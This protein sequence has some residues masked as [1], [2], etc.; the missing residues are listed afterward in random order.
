EREVQECTARVLGKIR[1]LRQRVGAGEVDQLALEVGLALAGAATRV[2]DRHA[3]VLLGERLD[4]GLVVRLL[5]RR[6]RAVERCAR[7]AAR[8]ARRRAAPLGLRAA[9]AARGSDERQRYCCDDE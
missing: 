6:P 3:G 2:V 7:K 4:R 5:E 8:R 9:A 1:G